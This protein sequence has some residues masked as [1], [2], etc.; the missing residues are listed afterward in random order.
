VGYPIIP[1]QVQ[2]VVH[3]SGS[4]RGVAKRKRFPE[5]KPVLHISHNYLYNVT[6][7]EDIPNAHIFLLRMLTRHGKAI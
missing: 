3:R 2:G 6:I 1:D 4:N 5:K 7:K